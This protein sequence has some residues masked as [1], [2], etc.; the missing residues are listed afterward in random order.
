MSWEPAGPLWER[1]VDTKGNGVGCKV[2]WLKHH[3]SLPQDPIGLVSAPTGLW[4]GAA[5]RG[6]PNR[7]EV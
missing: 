5:C 4:M 3:L 7:G 6:A 1:Q 2:S